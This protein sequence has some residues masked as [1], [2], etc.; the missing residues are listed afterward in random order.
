MNIKKFIANSPQE[1]LTMVKKE[2]GPE[3]VILETRTIGPVEGYAGKGRSRIEVTAAI[4]YE[5][6]DNSSALGKPSTEAQDPAKWAEL[7]GRLKDIWDSL[8]ALEAK[9]L[10]RAVTNQEVVYHNYFGLNPSVIKALAPEGE[11]EA[12][13]RPNREVV[14]ECLI[15]VLKQIHPIPGQGRIFSF[16]G[17]TGVGKTTTLAKLAALSSVRH[18]KRTA[19]ITVDTFR[20][21]AVEQLQTYARIMDIPLS[22]ASNAVELKRAI[23]S[24]DGFDLIFIDTAG[25]SPGNKRDLGR[26]FA[27]FN[28]GDPIHH[29]LVLS[30]TTKLQDLW[31]AE[32]R[33]GALPL[34]SYIFTKL[35]EATDIS[36]MLNFLL[37]RQRPISYFTMGQRVPE[38]I[39]RA[40][41][42]RMAEW[43]LKRKRRVEHEITTGAGGDGS[44]QPAQTYS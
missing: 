3:A 43:I 18:G 7:E 20:I 19:L 22:V 2:M 23:R 30:A 12:N 42:R 8:M 5:A 11:R 29:Y 25:R 44:S 17:P 16:V 40:T 39:E 24:Y 10:R 27:T 37:S 32:S 34:G 13:P 28:T 33:F 9:I 14:K 4:D 21:G 15:S 35:D 38:D 36:D 6:L 1:A 31:M 41:R 26:L